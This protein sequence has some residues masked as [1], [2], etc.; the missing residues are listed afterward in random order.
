MP[1]R[2]GKNNDESRSVFGN[3]SKGSSSDASGVEWSSC[4]P[5]LIVRLI[6]TATS[7]GGAVR[8]GYTRD[9]GAYAIGLY[10]GNDHTTEY[11]RPSEDVNE[12]LTEWIEFY[13]GL[14]MTGGKS[15]NG[16]T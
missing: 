16:T 8:F 2:I 14:P 1:K 3:R 15:P 7:R 9:G 12:F 6:D 4:N 5:D 13:S 11:C 10:Y